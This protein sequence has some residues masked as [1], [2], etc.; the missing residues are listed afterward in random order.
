[1]VFRDPSAENHQIS[2]AHKA[3]GWLCCTEI[4]GEIDDHLCV[5]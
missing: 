2:S 5:D 4:G 3:G 1:M